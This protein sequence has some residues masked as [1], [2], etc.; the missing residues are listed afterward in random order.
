MTFP[1]IPGNRTQGFI[2]PMAVD[3]HA[4]PRAELFGGKLAVMTDGKD[5]YPDFANRRHHWLT[6]SERLGGIISQS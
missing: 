3:V 1:G 5:R 4:K 6:V 2:A